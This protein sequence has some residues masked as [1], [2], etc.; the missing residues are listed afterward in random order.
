MILDP[1]KAA[2]APYLWAIRAGAGVL[3]VLLVFGF[4]W[5]RGA[6]RWQGKFDTETAAHK[7]T[8]AAHASVL[9][10]LANKT[11]AAEAAVKAAGEQA[12]ADRQA[13]DERFKDAR[14]EADQ[15]KRELARALRAG[16]VRLRDEFT[17]P[18]A[19]P[20]EGGASATAGRQDAAP[21]L[22]REREAAISDDIAEADAA[23]NW[24][25]WL[26]A[27]LIS[28]RKACGAAP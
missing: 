23:D 13:N 12:K 1:I 17:C 2:V 21:D 9:R 19:R 26:Q 14:H 8:K 11:K 28:T 16:T 18:A 24:I 3:A 15:A 25:G 5:N 4:G 22:R 7:A 20:A 10:D 6:D 27:E